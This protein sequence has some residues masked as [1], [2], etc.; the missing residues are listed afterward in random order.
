MSASAL[1]KSL[2]LLGTPAPGWRPLDAVSPVGGRPGGVTTGRPS[3]VEQGQGGAD[4]TLEES[5]AALREYYA[6]RIITT[7][8]GLFTLEV[9][10]IKRVALVDGGAILF[11]EPPP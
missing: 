4:A 11:K 6:S 1:Q 5:D 3:S 10:P 9:R 2:E 7:T 8:D